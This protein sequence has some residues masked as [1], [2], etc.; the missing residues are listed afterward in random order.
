MKGEPYVQCLASGLWSR[1][2]SNC[3]SMLIVLNVSGF[4]DI[5]HFLSGI[6][7]PKPELPGGAKILYGYT[8]LYSDKVVIACTETKI[9]EIVC[10]ADGQWSQNLKQICAT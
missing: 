7:C 10:N 8:F 9:V 6:S 3:S 1:N 4:Y 5:F 2:I